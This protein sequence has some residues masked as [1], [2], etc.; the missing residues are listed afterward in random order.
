MKKPLF[1]FYKI[2]FLTLLF[3]VCTLKAQ[4]YNLPNDYAYSLLTERGLALKDSS[5]HATI[6]PYIP[7][8][9]DKYKH[10]EDTH[11]VLKYITEDQFLDKVFFDHLIHIKSKDKKYLLTVDP[12][13]NL[14]MGRDSEDTIFRRLYTN[15]R[16]F[17]ATGSIGKN[18]YFET[19]FSENQSLFPNYIETLS[20][21]TAVVPGQGRW[22]TFN[23]RG[24]DYS[25]SSGFFSYQPCKNINIQAGHGKHKIGQGY[26]SLFLSDNAFNYPFV[27]ITQN[28]FKGRLQ[29]T[30]IYA[31]FMNLES[32]SKKLPPHTE[33]LFQKKAASFQHLSLNFTKWFNLG[34]F[35]GLI[36]QTA[37]KRNVQHFDWQYFNPVIFTNLPYYGLNNKNNILIGADLNL[38]ITKRISVYGQIMAD[39]LSNNNSLGNGWGYQAG[40]KYFDAFSLKNLFLQAEFNNVSEGSYL[41]PVTTDTANQ[42]YSHYNQNIAFTPGYGQELLFIADYKVKRIFFNA[43]YNY[44]YYT[45]NGYSLFTNQI[46]NLKFGYT[47]NPA[48]NANISIGFMYRAQDYFGFNVSNNKTAYL[49]LSFK[50]NIYNNY[51]DF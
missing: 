2:S 25:F 28:Y 35:Q 5:I 43:K 24:F 8:F 9:S 27:R 39:D 30:N 1:I 36:W 49:Y 16:G 34:F 41:S 31:S 29:Y 4:F 7:F 44:Q 15:T 21:A 47:I 11:R 17:V 23:S 42:S 51:Y 50:T 12:L 22:K 37:N 20:K 46:T 10:V 40:I 18:F 3:S 14:E 32:A 33:P 19:M 26:R 6:K 13:L 38:K 48:Y 45:Y